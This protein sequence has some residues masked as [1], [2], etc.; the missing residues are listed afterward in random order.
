MGG[1]AEVISG[2]AVERVLL[3]DYTKDSDEFRALMAALAAKDV[4][5]E[6]IVS[7]ENFDFGDAR[8]YVWPP[9]SY[10][11]AG[12]WDGA[13]NELSLIASVE[14]GDVKMLFTG[15][16]TDERLA[17]W[18]EGSSSEKY[19][20]VKIPHHGVYCEKLEAL[21]QST[22]PED[23]VI[24][25]SDKN[26]ADEKTL[27]LLGD[28]GVKIYETKDGDITATGDGHTLIVSQ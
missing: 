16:A 18:L 17:E 10:A 2:I 15:D 21:L 27:A 19:D 20:L 8:V 26:P 12:T 22:A 7:P 11:A 25:D 13:D 4:T 1:A 5:P 28:M 23:A 9:E 6:L 24:C 14:H 3:P